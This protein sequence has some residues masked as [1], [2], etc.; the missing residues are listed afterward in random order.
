[1]ATIGSGLRAIAIATGGASTK[2]M[3]IGVATL[4]LTS[5]NAKKAALTGWLF[6]FAR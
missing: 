1:M 6:F 3:G 5:N 2:D 4:G